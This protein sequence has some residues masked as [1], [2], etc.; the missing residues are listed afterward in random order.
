[1]AQQ[2]A[3]EWG[4]VPIVKRERPQDTDDLV[5]Q[6]LAAAAESLGLPS[7]V[8]VVLVYGPT[9]SGAGQ[10]NLIVVREVGDTPVWEDWVL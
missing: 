1:M 2:L 8:P 10:T 7:G 6:L 5:A 3:L 4:V 9:G